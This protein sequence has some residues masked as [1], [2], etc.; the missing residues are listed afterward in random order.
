MFLCL[1]TFINLIVFQKQAYKSKVYMGLSVRKYAIGQKKPFWIV[2]QMLI[3]GNVCM[4]M[5][6]FL[7]LIQIEAE[8]G[9]VITHFAF[10]TKAKKL[11][12]RLC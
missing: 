5:L 4:N 6:L 3:W 12:N 10:S 11:P 1:N 9:V 8:L 2:I 7:L